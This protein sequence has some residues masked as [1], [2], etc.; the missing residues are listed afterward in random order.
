[1][2]RQYFQVLSSLRRQQMSCGGVEEKQ[3]QG[4]EVHGH[5]VPKNAHNEII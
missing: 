2:L 5:S 1:M 3:G 4:D